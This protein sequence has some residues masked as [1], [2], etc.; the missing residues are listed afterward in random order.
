MK[1]LSDRIWET[2]KTRIYTEKRLMNNELITERLMIW[3]SFFLVVAS[4]CSLKTQGVDI[5]LYCTVGSIFVLVTSIYLSA[6]RYAS[7]AATMKSHYISLELLECSVRN[8][9]DNENMAELKNL[10]K[11][12]CALLNSIENHSD[13]DYLKLRFKRRNGANTT[14]GRFNTYDHLLYVCGYTIRT[15]SIII[16]FILPIIFYY[17]VK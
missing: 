9:E 13:W 16:L 6:Q 4:V 15:L 8:E 3:Y 1:K 5:S 12:Y 17:L 10:E 14:L 7:R 2:R 11:S